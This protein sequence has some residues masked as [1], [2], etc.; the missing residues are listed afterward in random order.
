MKAGSLRECKDARLPSLTFFVG[1]RRAQQRLRSLFISVHLLLMGAPLAPPWGRPG[2]PASYNHWWMARI[3]GTRK[4]TNA[5][6]IAKGNLCTT[7]A[8]EFG[9]KGK[10]LKSVCMQRGI[11]VEGEFLSQGQHAAACTKMVHPFSKGSLDT[12]VHAQALDSSARGFRLMS[13]R[14]VYI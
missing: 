11:I 14:A 9:R 10:S 4:K 6:A 2:S 13:S 12:F 1:D 3:R 5:V 8:K 7:A